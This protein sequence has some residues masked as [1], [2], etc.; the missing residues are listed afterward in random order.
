MD[1]YLILAGVIFSAFFIIWAIKLY[2]PRSH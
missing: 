2:S 1:G